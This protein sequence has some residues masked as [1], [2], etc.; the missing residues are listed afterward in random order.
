M[1]SATAIHRLQPSRRP[2]AAHRLHVHLRQGQCTRCRPRDGGLHA[3][4]GR[5]AR[6]PDHASS[7]LPPCRPKLYLILRAKALIMVNSRCIPAQDV[8]VTPHTAC[9]HACLL[10]A[11]GTLLQH[12]VFAEPVITPQR[13]YTARLC[14]G[15]YRGGINDLTCVACPAGTFSASPGATS[16]TAAP[17][18]TYINNTASTSATPCPAGACSP[19]C[20]R[21]D[22]CCWHCS[23]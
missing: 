22:R 23:Q 19:G 7:G 15:T 13:R 20:E 2:D 14:A 9:R 10:L 21:C 17:A 8:R 5:R 11:C 4:H 3:L 12:Q 16:C 6:V 1:L 18:G